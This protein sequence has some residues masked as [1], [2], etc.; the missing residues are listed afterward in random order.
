[1]SKTI[2]IDGRQ[3]IFQKVQTDDG[4]MV[5][6]TLV[7]VSGAGPTTEYREYREWTGKGI[8]TR[9][10]GTI[11]EPTPAETEVARDQ[12]RAEYD[13]LDATNGKVKADKAREIKG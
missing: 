6:I 10:D 7:P 11:I 12:V 4:G 8:F 5:L 3:V 1:M 9:P 2:T 13:A